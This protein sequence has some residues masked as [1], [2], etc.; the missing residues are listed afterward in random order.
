MVKWELL[1][2]SAKK[3]S[4]WP[5]LPSGSTEVLGGM[6]PELIRRAL[7]EHLEQ[8]RHCYQKQLN[9][10][11]PG[12]APEG[13]MNMHFFIGS[14]GQVTKSDMSGKNI[15]DQEVQGCVGKVLEGI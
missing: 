8:F 1:D 9:T 13:I 14:Q 12:Q 4:A 11:A 7:R 2:L 15:S 6:D 5:G 10:L 3:G